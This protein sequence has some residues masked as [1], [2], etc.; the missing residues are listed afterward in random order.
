MSAQTNESSLLL[1]NEW[2]R[3][4]E[5]RKTY[6]QKIK[7]SEKQPITNIGPDGTTKSM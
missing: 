1:L 6:E 4:K 7:I 3:K 5:A 2:K